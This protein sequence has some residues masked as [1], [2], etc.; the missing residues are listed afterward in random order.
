M[1]TSLGTFLLATCRKYTDV[2]A[3]DSSS[4]ILWNATATCKLYLSWWKQR[5]R[6]LWGGG[7]RGAVH[8]HLVRDAQVNRVAVRL[9]LIASAHTYC[10][11][12]LLTPICT[13]L[14]NI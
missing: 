13:R 5:E 2:V 8:L 7:G 9:L 3:I 10:L 6:G 14:S 12:Q 1:L 4:D 11:L